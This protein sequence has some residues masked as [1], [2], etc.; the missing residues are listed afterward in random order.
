M[1]LINPGSK[2]KGGTIEE[3]RIIADSFLDEVKAIGIKGVT[4][5]EGEKLEDGDF[6]FDFTHP[7]TGVVVN[8]QTHGF[9]IEELNQFL[10]SPRVYWG[11]SSTRGPELEDF[12]KEGFV[13]VVKYFPNKSN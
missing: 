11:E 9:N 6:S 13:R 4:V 2:N 1:I 8:L 7:V 10:F 12:D 3:A 5:S